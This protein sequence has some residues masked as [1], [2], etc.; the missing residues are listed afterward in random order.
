MR[1]TKEQ[2]MAY[3]EVIEILKY[4]PKEDTNKIPREIVKYYTDNMDTSYNFKIDTKKTF[5]EQELLKKTKIVL[6]I[7]FRDYWATEKQRERIKQ[8]EAHDI[9]VLELDKKQKYNSDNIFKNKKEYKI[10][11]TESLVEYKKENWYEKFL[12]F[13]KRVFRINKD[14]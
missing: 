12:K 11:M 3:T 13:M 7:L 1:I 4:M 5:K 2:A 10:E 6:A 8:K 9:Y 14:E